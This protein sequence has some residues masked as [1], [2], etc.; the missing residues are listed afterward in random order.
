MLA[1]NDE[2]HMFIKEIQNLVEE[3]KRISRRREQGP[4]NTSGRMKSND[5]NKWRCMIQKTRSGHSQYQC[6]HEVLEVYKKGFLDLKC[7]KW[8]TRQ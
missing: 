6:F 3:M 1:Q 4:Q 2:L 5:E 7:Q 8:P